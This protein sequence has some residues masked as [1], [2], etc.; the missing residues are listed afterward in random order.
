MLAGYG[1]DVWL[2]RNSHESSDMPDIQKNG[3]LPNSHRSHGNDLH[4]STQSAEE[5]PLLKHKEGELFYLNQ[6]LQIVKVSPPHT[7]THRILHIHTIPTAQI[8]IEYN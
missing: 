4:V 7:H 1:L 3:D 5:T 2:Q 6:Y 8:H